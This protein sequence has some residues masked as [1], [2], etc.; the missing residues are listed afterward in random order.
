MIAGKN[1]TELLDYCV[2]TK[3]LKNKIFHGCKKRRQAGKDVQLDCVFLEERLKNGL[4]FP[5]TCKQIHSAA[6][7]YEGN[8]LMFFY[9]QNNN[10][11]TVTKLRLD[12]YRQ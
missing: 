1:N 9:L 3:I 11:Q 2:V 7:A 6:Q 5:P 4:L 10:C 12:V 8:I